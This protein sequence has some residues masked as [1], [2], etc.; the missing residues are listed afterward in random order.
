MKGSQ[1]IGERVTTCFQ[2]W[3]GVQHMGEKD[4]VRQQEEVIGAVH[5]DILLPE[6]I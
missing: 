4:S 2:L 5:H 1:E 3:V 6:V